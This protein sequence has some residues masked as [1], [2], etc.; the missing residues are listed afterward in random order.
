MRGL[1]IGIFILMIL[2]ATNLGSDPLGLESQARIEQQTQ[3]QLAQ[4]QLQQ[5]QLQAQAQLEAQ[6]LEQAARMQRAQLLAQYVQRLPLTIGIIC[7][8][9]L[10]GM[11]LHYGWKWRMMAMAV[12]PRLGS[13]DL[14]QDP[15]LSQ[16]SPPSSLVAI[17]MAEV[18]RLHH[19]AQ[20]TGHRVEVIRQGRHH[21]ALL[22]DNATGHIQ[23]QRVFIL[24]GEG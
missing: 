12:N 8:A 13:T 10:L 15:P 6:R 1:V 14:N 11:G 3:L 23:A 22:V 4:L 9:V 17:S 16:A 5:A 18:Q 24:A 7:A 20:G 21:Q 2:G 19:Q